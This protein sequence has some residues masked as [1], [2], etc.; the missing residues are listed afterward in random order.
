MS[1]EC[2]WR[3][4]RIRTN[5]QMIRENYSLEHYGPR[6]LKIYSGLM[7]EPAGNLDA[8]A[9]EAILEGFLA[10]ERLFLLRT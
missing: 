5:R 8:L 10:P 3:P 2:C 1:R 4:E 9:G 7:E 6:L